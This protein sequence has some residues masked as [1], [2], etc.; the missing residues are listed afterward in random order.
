MPFYDYK[1]NEESCLHLWEEMQGIN[2]P[3]LTICPKCGKQSVER[4]I[5]TGT[6]FI[7]VGGGWGAD[8]YGN[9]K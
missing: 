6:G 9:K 7:L 5:S 1:C 4:L 8:L 3:K 2:E